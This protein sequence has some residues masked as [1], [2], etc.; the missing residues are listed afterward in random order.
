MPAPGSTN[1][2]TVGGTVG[3]ML[4]HQRAIDQMLRGLIVPSQSEWM[5]G[6]R[7]LRAAPLHARELPRDAKLAPALLR[8]EEAV[9]RLAEEA[10]GADTVAAKE[11]VYSTL[12]TRC[13]D[14]HGLHK[15][16]W[17]PPPGT[18]PSRNDR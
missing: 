11:R 18:A 2:P 9:H 16:I 3:H 4:D 1:M 17:G 15:G 7:G 10:I 6:A 13:A 5:N 14:C 8:V 12:L